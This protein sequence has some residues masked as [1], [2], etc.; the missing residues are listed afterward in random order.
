MNLH[1]RLSKINSINPF[2]PKDLKKAQKAN[3]FIGRGSLASS[4]HK[5]AQAAG[6]LA[7]CGMYEKEDIVFV[8]VEGN[9]RGREEFSQEEAL[10][11]IKAHVSFVT[12]NLY[13]RS[14]PYN[15]GERAFA[16][17]LEENNYTEVAPGIWK[18]KT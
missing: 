12:D 15:I 1:E 9:R 11:A 13:D 8:S 17:F 14:R 2:F 7:N 3:K 10:K 4:T 6:D 5:Y 18:P 16:K